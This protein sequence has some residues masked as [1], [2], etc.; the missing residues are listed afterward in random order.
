MNKGYLTREALMEFFSD[1]IDPNP[2]HPPLISPDL[3][4]HLI[5]IQDAIDGSVTEACCIASLI[6]YHHSDMDFG[7]PDDGAVKYSYKAPS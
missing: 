3:A 7:G 4:F 2:P 5:T 1:E 6:A